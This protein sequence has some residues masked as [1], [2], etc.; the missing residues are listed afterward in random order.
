MI[1]SL[2]LLFISIDIITNQLICFRLVSL[3]D[4]FQTK[5][6]QNVTS[7]HAPICHMAH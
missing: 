5:M 4:F 7:K 6:T 1:P 3:T 2:D